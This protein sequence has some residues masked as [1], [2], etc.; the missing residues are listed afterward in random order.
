MLSI[1]RKNT[2]KEC[3]TIMILSTILKIVIL[4]SLL[5]NIIDFDNL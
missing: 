3:F 1:K 5:T 4:T 2:K